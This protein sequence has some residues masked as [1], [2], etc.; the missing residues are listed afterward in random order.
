MEAYRFRLQKLLD[1]KKHL[2]S[3]RKLELAKALRRLARE[4]QRLVEMHSK[5]E[6]WRRQKMERPA[7]RLDLRQEELEWDRFRGLMEDIRRQ[8][9]A[10]KHSQESVARERKD[11]VARKMERRILDNL[12]KRGLIQHMREW[13][14]GERCEQDEAGRDVYIRGRCIEK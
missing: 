6:E 4:E 9:D 11:L 3:R 13:L 2:E 1:V 12:K 7:R 10:V 14:R 5:S 8:T